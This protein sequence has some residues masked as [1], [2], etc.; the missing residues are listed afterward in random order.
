MPRSSSRRSWP[1]PN[2]RTATRRSALGAEIA[3]GGPSEETH[4]AP[5]SPTGGGALAADPALLPS[6]RRRGTGAP[7]A[8]LLAPRE[9]RRVQEGG[10]AR[11]VAAGAAPRARRTRRCRAARAPSRGSPRLGRRLLAAPAAARLFRVSRPPQHDHPVL[12]PNIRKLVIA[13]DVVRPRSCRN[14]RTGGAGAS[15]EAARPSRPRAGL[16]R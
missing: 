7:G 12:R 13:H 5:P 4:F 8:M 1:R 6:S 11:A 14:G 10:G 3:D 2:W 15:A 9:H 16:P